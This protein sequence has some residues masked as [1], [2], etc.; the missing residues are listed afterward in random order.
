ME[1]LQNEL[2]AYSAKYEIAMKEKMLMK[3]ERDRL[4]AKLDNL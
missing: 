4:K 3:L 2:S 1:M